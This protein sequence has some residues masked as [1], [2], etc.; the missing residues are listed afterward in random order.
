MDSLT[1]RYGLSVFEGV[2]LYQQASGPRVRPF[3]LAEHLRRLA[4]SLVLTR[5]PDPGIAAI[6]KI[7]AE[8]VER[9]EIVDDAYIRIAVSAGNPG[10]ISDD[11]EPVLTVG[12]TPMGRK[13]WLKEE[14]GMKL[15]I[16]PWQRAPEGAFPA[17]AKNISAYAGSRLGALTAKD[18]GY[19]GCVLVNA[20]GRLCEAPTA[21]LFILRDGVLR[22]P[23]LTEGVLPSITRR[24]TLT[25][26]AGLGMPI[27]ECLVSRTDAYLA[28]EAFLCG[29][30]LEFAPVRSFDGRECGSWPDNSV[31]RC[32]IDLYFR[33][34][35]GGGT[36]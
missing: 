28:D 2:R 18:S 11:V 29:T 19:D 13:Q 33:E 5:M 12:A 26:A 21:A 31:T 32:L 14:K 17:A 7:V 16:S 23:V 36:S 30:G 1:L 24:W 8:L 22:T 15:Q 25:A 34:V 27:A 4:N 20:D 35:R 10:L 3:M 6:P 9:N